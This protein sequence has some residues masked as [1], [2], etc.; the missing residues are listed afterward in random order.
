MH[1]PFPGWE[2]DTVLTARTIPA[3]LIPRRA[4]GAVVQGSAWTLA[5][6]CASA[7]LAQNWEE[8]VLPSAGERELLGTVPPHRHR[9]PN[10]VPGER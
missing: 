9:S 3:V 2:W 5:P 7:L 1:S 4:A 10:I 8:G 6:I